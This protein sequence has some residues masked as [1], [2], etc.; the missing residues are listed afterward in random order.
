MEYII[1]EGKKIDFKQQMEKMNFVTDIKGYTRRFTFI[2]VKE[3]RLYIGHKYKGCT[4]LL[5]EFQHKDLK[6]WIAYFD[7]I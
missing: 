4:G 7:R 3:G 1:V 2:T 6:M 5:S